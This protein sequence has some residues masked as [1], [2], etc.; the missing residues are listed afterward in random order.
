MVIPVFAKSKLATL[1]QQK[2]R[3]QLTAMIKTQRKC[4]SQRSNSCQLEL[5]FPRILSV[6]VHCILLGVLYPK[7][8]LF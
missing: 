1:G 5:A 6:S 8:F 2:T 7:I 3:E 4:R